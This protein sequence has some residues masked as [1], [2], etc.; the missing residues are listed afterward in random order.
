MYAALYRPM[1]CAVCGCG[2]SPRGPQRPAPGATRSWDRPLN[3]TPATGRSS[4]CQSVWL[5]H[6]C[7]SHRVSHLGSL[8]DCGSD[9]PRL[10]RTAIRQDPSSSVMCGT[11]KRMIVDCGHPPRRAHSG[12]LSRFLVFSFSTGRRQ[13]QSNAVPRVQTSLLV[14]RTQGR[15]VL[16]RFLST[17]CVVQAYA[18]P[19][20]RAKDAKK[21]DIALTRR[22][23]PL[24]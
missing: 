10:F 24:C 13:V 22:R 12:G 6:T 11:G 15:E 17:S 7:N 20:V 2:R 3:R 16:A 8:R 21:C 18:T 4:E 1:A 5:S 14:Q 19:R 9:P 23:R